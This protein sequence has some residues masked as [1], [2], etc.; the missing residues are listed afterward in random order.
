MRNYSSPR[1][2]PVSITRG[3]A[4]R[5]CG[6]H[7]TPSP[8]PQESQGRRAL[9]FSLLPLRSALRVLCVRSLALHLLMRRRPANPPRDPRPYF[10]G[11]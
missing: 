9:R 5:L 1:A 7:S 4:F 3:T 8:G 11:T 2:V 6:T 10:V